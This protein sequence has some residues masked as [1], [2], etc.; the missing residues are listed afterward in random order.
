MIEF[1]NPATKQRAPLLV[2]PHH[3]WV[4]GDNAE[5]SNDS[6]FFGP[7]SMNLVHDKVVY[8]VCIVYDYLCMFIVCYLSI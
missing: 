5:N 6:R 4:E 3:I 1:E 2:P 7:I 8:K